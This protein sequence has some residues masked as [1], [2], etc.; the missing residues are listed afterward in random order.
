MTSISAN[1]QRMDI[2]VPIE[3][4]L[5]ASPEIALKPAIP[6]RS[7]SFSKRNLYIT[8]FSTEFQARAAKFKEATGR[9][10][11]ILV[12]ENGDIIN[13][14]HPESTAQASFF[15]EF[16]RVGFSSPD[17]HMAAVKN[18]AR[19]YYELREELLGRYQDDQYALYERLGELN[20]AFE[21][22]LQNTTLLPLPKIPTTAILTDDTP[23]PVRAHAEQTWRN[24]ENMKSIIR[25]VQNSMSRGMDTFFEN[26]IR[27]IQNQD[28]QSAFDNSMADLL[29]GESQ[30]LEEMSFADAVR[31]RDTLS[32][33]CIAE[34]E[35]GNPI[36][37]L[38]SFDSSFRAIVRDENISDVL[39]KEIAELLGL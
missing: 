39:R 9:E 24:Y 6:A 3:N 7:Q 8:D 23:A 26:F 21:S 14:F 22:A 18:L 29:N 5:R 30:S 38:N 37:R 28:F 25:H 27:K 34:D 10:I 13:K 32:R 2:A 19:R 31:I 17:G 1:L 12:N 35:D 33:W 20:Q 11:E 16:F 4:R 15:V 36:G